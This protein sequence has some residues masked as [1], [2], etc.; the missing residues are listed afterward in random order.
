MRRIIGFAAI[1]VVLISYDAVAADLNGYTARYECRAGGPYCNVD[2]ESLAG[3][4]SV[5]DQIIDAWTP[6]SSINWSNNT[7][8]IEAGDHTGKGELIIPTSANGSAGNYKVLRYSRPSDNDDDP[9]QQTSANQAKI[10]GMSISADYW[11]IERLSFSGTVRFEEGADNNIVDRILVDGAGIPIDSNDVTVQNSVVRNTPTEGGRDHHCTAGYSGTL[12]LRLVNNE[13]Y[14]CAGDGFQSNSGNDCFG[15][16]VE[17]NDM[18]ATSAMYCDKSGNFTPNGAYAASEQAVDIKQGGQAGEP[19]MI[20]HN[21]VWGFRRTATSCG[22]T[23]SAGEGIMINGLTAGDREYVLV[24][25]NIITDVPR[26]VAIDAD[27]YDQV[28]VVGNLAYYMRDPALGSSQACWQMGDAT[29]SE[30]YLNTCIDAPNAWWGRSRSNNDVRC[31]VS[32]DSAETGGS[33]GTTQ[34]NYNAYYGV[35]GTKY[36]SNVIDKALN[37]IRGT[38]CTSLGCTSTANT[39]GRSVGD[40]VRTS[41]DPRAD[42]T[43]VNDQDC[44]LYKVLTAGTSG[45]VKAVRGPYAFYRKLRTAPEQYVV[46]YAR[47]YGGAPNDLQSSAPEAYA[48]PPNFAERLGIGI[49]DIN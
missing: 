44:F 27:P 20:I 30:L 41:T 1:L 8:C 17:N 38:L 25:N 6:W 48:C 13:I 2:V 12:R 28:S 24:Q 4:R 16:V 14:N 37:T 47:P 34:V 21:R 36:D 29:D 31:N 3:P 7:I 22:S 39:T 26:A 18:Y 19:V 23:G 40:I 10:P 45:S 35:P 32:I 5:C 11:I 43:S 15:C 42:C 49:N 9:W 33:I 46:P